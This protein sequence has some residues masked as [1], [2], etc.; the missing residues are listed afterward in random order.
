MTPELKQAIEMLQYSQLELNEFLQEELMTNPVLEMEEPAHVKTE[1]LHE[2]DWRRVANQ[3]NEKGHTHMAQDSKDDEN[4][5]E[6]TVSDKDSLIDHLM[7]Q[8]KFAPLGEQQREIGAFL[9]ENIDENGYLDIELKEAAEKYKISFDEMND[10]LMVLQTFEPT[11][12]LARDLREC[13]LIQIRAASFD[14]SIAESIV[15][16]HLNELADNKMDRIAK[17]LGHSI[18]IIQAACDYIKTLEPKPGR[19]FFSGDEVR[20][21]IPDVLVDYAEEGFIIQVSDSTAPKLYISSYYQ[22]ILNQQNDEGAT[23]YIHKKLNAALKLIKSIEQRR[24][25]IHKVVSAI[26]D[27]QLEFFL[28]GPL[29]LKTLTL[30]DIADQIGMHESTVSRTVNGKYLQCKHGLFEMKYFFQSGVS[31]EMGDGVSAESIKKII[32]EQIDSEDPKKP[33][34]DQHISDQL[35]ELGIKISRRTVAKYRDEMLIASTSRR[36]RF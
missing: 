2:I 9:I 11:G 32:R 19:L 31:S 24:N 34:S 30:K 5:F 23:E 15:L 17:A 36:K 14:N 21:I 28:K 29:Y 4:A 33:L 26:T 6:S 1:E 18:A 16:N 20:Y 8:L 10:I 12:V 7:F 35:N 3:M 22:S 13:L 25:T 27:Q